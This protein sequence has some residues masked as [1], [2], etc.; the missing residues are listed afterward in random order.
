[1]SI[2]LYYFGFTVYP[3]QIQTEFQKTKRIRN[4][5]KQHIYP[6]QTQSHISIQNTQNSQ[7]IYLSIYIKYS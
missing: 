4:L 6:T 1:M 3:T 5:G 2:V 7:S